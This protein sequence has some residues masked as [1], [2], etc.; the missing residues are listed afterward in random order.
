MNLIDLNTGESAIIK[1]VRGIGSFRRR[2]KE[3]GFVEGKKVEVIKSAPLLDPVEYKI[4]G[5]NISLRKEEAE[6][7]EVSEG[8]NKYKNCSSDNSVPA[9][10][11]FM[12]NSCS[13]K[14]CVQK[15]CKRINV[16]LVGNPNSGKTTLFNFIS[17]L[18]ER[19][20][21]YS[22]VTVEGKTAEVVFGEYVINITDLPGTYSLTSF[23]TDEKVVHDFIINEIPDIIINVVDASN[24]ERNMYLTTQLIDMDL[25]IIVALNMFDELES[26]GTKFDHE[27]LSKMTGIPF[28]PTVASKKIGITEL[29]SEVVSCYN[30][31]EPITRHIHIDYGHPIED[32]IRN[33]RTVL[34][35][36]TSVGFVSKISPRYTSLKLLENDP[37]FT[38][39]VKKSSTNYSEIDA[40]ISAELKVIA[41]HYNDNAA[42]IITDARY[43]FISGALKETLQITSSSPSVKRT[44]RI[45]EFATDR[46]WGIPIFIALMWLMFK[47]TFTL[48][49]YPMM[50]IE[51]LISELA[52]FFQNI[53]ADG[54]FK[55][56][57]VDGIIGG[58]GGVLVFLPNILILFFFISF[59]EDTGYMARVVFIVDKVMHK[60]GLHGKSFIPM[61]IGFGCSVPAI[62]ATRTINS[63]NNRLVTMMI[64]P[65]MSCGAKLPVYIL[66]IGAFF[67]DNPAFMLFVVYSIGVFIAMIS[68]LLLKKTLFRIEDVPFV[69]ELPPYRVPTFKSTVY[70]MWDKAFQ[71]LKKMGGVILIASLI[72]WA[73]GYFPRPVNGQSD[74]KFASLEESYIGKIGK[75]VEP[76]FDPIGFDWK[77]NVAI[78]SGFAAKEIVVSTLSILHYNEEGNDL[79]SKLKNSDSFDY[80]G[81][82]KLKAFT[83]LMFVLLYLPCIATVIAIKNE[84]GSWKWALFSAAF[85]T[86]VAWIISF[87][88]FNTGMLII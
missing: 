56:L 85:T 12:C 41:D 78:I 26:S 16:A 62:M 7:I 5:Y 18:R 53:L 28:I 75:F 79:E 29:L 83:F 71:Y 25:K 70:H 35:K 59:F 67:P 64:I 77:S 14:V 43:G 1:K 63:R 38:A 23:S 54:I 48:G 32:S 6:L 10:Q 80:N 61:L 39:R 33:I 31:E 58:V 4:M 50:F 65:F 69:M 49:E 15:K 11:S 34:L 72:V 21:N 82:H 8:G 45:D 76:V 46:I 74:D 60:I 52:G 47:S 42:D 37:D 40:A 17:G 20:G 13:S 66:I 73:L 24:I 36:D 27:Y 57:L 9:I 87:I 30:D 51:Y 2:L 68:A 81:S 3:M 44:R 88:I 55:D 19:V 84:S 22:G 86:S